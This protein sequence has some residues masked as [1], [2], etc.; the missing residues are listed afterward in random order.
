M[1]GLDASDG[2][3]TGAE[4]DEVRGG[5][6][7]DHVTAVEPGRGGGG[8]GRVGADLPAL[9]RSLRGGGRG[10]SLRPPPGPGFGAARAG[11]RGGAGAGAVRHPLLG[12]HR[13]ALPREAGRRARLRAQLQLGAADLAGTRAHAR[14]AQARCTPAQAPAPC[15][16]R[17]DGA[18]GWLAPRVG[19]RPLVGPDRDHGRRHQ[20][21]LLGLLRRRGGHDVELAGACRG[22][23]G[24]RA[25]LL[26]L[27]RP[28]QPLLAH[29][30]GRRQSRQGQ[31]DP[32]RPCLDAA[33][34]RADP[35]LFARG[36]GAV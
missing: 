4:I 20:H 32:G 29:A 16:S 30:R 33:R 25:V 13:Q 18:P 19:A 10:R 15:A 24:A 35:G 22:D 21:D 36:Q 31:S 11:G 26:A 27:C 9:A 5:V 8:A 7:A 23:P 6:C 14:G 17:H 28:C 3:G 1:E 34:H 12:L 2:A